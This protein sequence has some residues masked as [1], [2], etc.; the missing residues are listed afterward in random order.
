MYCLDTSAVIELMYATQR[1]KRIMEIVDNGPLL[2]SSL[3][4][5]ELLYGMKDKELEIINQFL[6]DVR[7]IPFDQKAAKQSS[8]IK[9]QLKARGLLINDLDILIAGICITQNLI[10]LTKDTD[11]SRI[12]DLQCIIL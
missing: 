2:V 11:Y 4:I 8:I 10:L 9:R 7:I 1:G 12:Q 6:N 5:Y 3:T